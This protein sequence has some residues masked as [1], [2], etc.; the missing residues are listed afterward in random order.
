MR[1]PRR[2]DR[3]VQLRLVVEYEGTRFLGWQLQPGGA[4]VQGELERALGVVLRAPVR[5]RFLSA[6]S[7]RL[8]A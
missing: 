2:L 5:V 8:V 4:T 6:D 7:A 1:S 3:S